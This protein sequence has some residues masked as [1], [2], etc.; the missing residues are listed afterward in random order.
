MYIPCYDK[1]TVGVLFL[2]I[3]LKN[4]FLNKIF[5]WQSNLGRYLNFPH[6]F[7]FIQQVWFEILVKT[8][9]LLKYKKRLFLRC[10]EWGQKQ[11]LF[12]P[13]NAHFEY[14]EKM[15]HMIFKIFFRKPYFSRRWTKFLH[16]F[17]FFY[18]FF[19]FFLKIN[20]K[21]LKINGKALKINEKTWFIGGE[22]LIYEFIFFLFSAYIWSTHLR[23]Q[24]T[25]VFALILSTAEKGVFCT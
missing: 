16:I 25:F 19:F 24:I 1:I 11:T 3:K 23:A 12:A 15:K 5:L 4:Y 14:R 21:T 18:T 13:L 17:I 10:S 2:N 7:F 6:I 9:F 22:I 8:H 20:G